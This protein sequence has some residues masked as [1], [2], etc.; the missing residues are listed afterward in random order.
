M[1]LGEA[2]VGEGPQLVENS[3]GGAGGDS[4]RDHPLHQARAEGIHAFRRAFGSHGLAQHVGLGRTEA[5]SVNGYLHE[6]LLEEGDPEGLG[7]RGF[8]G[9][10]EIVHL[11]PAQTAADIGIDGVTLD[12]AG[13]D[14]SHLDNDVVED[15]R[16]QARQGG[17]LSAG[18]DLED[19]DCIRGAQ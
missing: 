3:L 17:H 6:L 16:A 13:T 14:H 18:L 4:H 2:E 10:M 19:A 12:G 8:E 9:F 1:G 5:G 7:Q 11:F 15:L